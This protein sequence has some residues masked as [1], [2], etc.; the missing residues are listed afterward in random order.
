MLMTDADEVKGVVEIEVVFSDS[1]DQ[2]AFDQRFGAGV[3][4]LSSALRPVS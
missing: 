4:V 3:V 1:D 2:E